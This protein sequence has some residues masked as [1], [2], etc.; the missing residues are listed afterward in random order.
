MGVGMLPSAD[1]T[2]LSNAVWHMEPIEVNIQ[3]LKSQDEGYKS[4]QQQQQQ[5]QQQPPP[6]PLLKVRKTWELFKF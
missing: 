6:P 2:P 5:Q 3:P 4:Q 1:L